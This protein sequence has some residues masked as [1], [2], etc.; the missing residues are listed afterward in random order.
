MPN[1][2]ATSL[3]LK[4]CRSFRHGKN[5]GIPASRKQSKHFNLPHEVIRT[6]GKTGT[7]EITDE[8]L[9]ASRNFDDLIVIIPDAKTGTKPPVLK[10]DPPIPPPRPEPKP[11]VEANIKSTEDEKPVETPKPEVKPNPVPPR[12]A[13]YGKIKGGG[14]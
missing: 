12:P 10:P 9:K 3:L 11:S 5:L 14:K 4:A 13:K 1:I 7:A 6:L 2:K 8:Q